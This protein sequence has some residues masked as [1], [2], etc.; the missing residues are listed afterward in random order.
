[1]EENN[2]P[3]PVKVI[4][5]NCKREIIGY[6]DECGK[7]RVTCPC[8]GAVTVSKIMGRRHVQLDVYAPKGQYLI[9]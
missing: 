8:C 9:Q 1:M 3:K 5:V 7:T 4:C 2:Y 6:R